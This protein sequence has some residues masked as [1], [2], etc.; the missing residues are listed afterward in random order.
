MLSVTIPSDGGVA[1]SFWQVGSNT[2]KP[3]WVCGHLAEFE[4]KHHVNI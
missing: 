1:E 4:S 3:W 2:L